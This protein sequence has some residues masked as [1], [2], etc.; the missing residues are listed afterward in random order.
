MDVSWNQTSNSDN[1]TAWAISTDGHRASCN[2]T[3]NSCSIHGLRCGKI[4]EVAVT[5][6]SV[7][8]D[9]IAGSDYRVASGGCSFWSSLLPTRGVKSVNCPLS[10]VSSGC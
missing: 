7:N 2:S 5:S 6:T 4:Y 1:Y 8:C 9:A 3:S 10:P